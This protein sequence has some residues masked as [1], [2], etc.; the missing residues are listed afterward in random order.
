MYSKDLCVF[1]KNV[2][3]LISSRHLSSD[4]PT[5]GQEHRIF[6]ALAKLSTEI[7]MEVLTPLISKPG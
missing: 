7:P 3:I 1:E 5:V 2:W 4:K 6:F